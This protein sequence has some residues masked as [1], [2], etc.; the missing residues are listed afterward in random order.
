MILNKKND[1]SK[2]IKF[3]LLNCAHIFW[4]EGVELPKFGDIGNDGSEKW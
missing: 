3:W 1:N 2:M 4:K